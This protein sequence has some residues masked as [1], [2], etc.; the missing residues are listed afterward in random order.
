MHEECGGEFKS[1]FYNVGWSEAV[2]YYPC[3]ENNSK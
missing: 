1:N 3:S 2:R